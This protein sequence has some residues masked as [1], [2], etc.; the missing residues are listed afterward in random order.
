VV[1]K[2]V[3]GLASASSRCLVLRRYCRTM[4]HPINGMH[5][6]ARA[7]PCTLAVMASLAL[8]P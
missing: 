6:S 3:I 4:A 2:M 8:N 1:N 7:R 5:S